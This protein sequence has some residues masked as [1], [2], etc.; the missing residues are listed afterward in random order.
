MAEGTC[1]STLLPVLVQLGALEGLSETGLAVGSDS[2]GITVF[3][4]SVSKQSGS[5]GIDSVN[6]TV[7]CPSAEERSPHETGVA[8]SLSPDS[9]SP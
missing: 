6:A 2:I 9:K 7:W 5:Q 8:T 3:G 4:A 1:D